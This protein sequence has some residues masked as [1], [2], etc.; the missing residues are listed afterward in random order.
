MNEL[1]NL[2]FM[3]E[4]LN[5]LLKQSP[6]IIMEA[7][8]IYFLVRYI[9]EK[10]KIIKEK[11]EIILDQTGKLMELYGEAVKSQNNL[12]NA[13]QELRKDVDRKHHP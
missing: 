6:I 4:F 7:L 10:N 12:T 5:I 13:I 8:G 9:K 3:S 2:V 1:D 11:D